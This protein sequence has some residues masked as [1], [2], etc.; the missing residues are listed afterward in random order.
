MD[1]VGQHLIDSPSNKNQE[2]HMNKQL[3]KTSARQGFTTR[4]MP[5]VLGI[6]MVLAIV[7]L[8][9]VTGFF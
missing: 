5:I 8:A 6:S 7:A 3:D 4:Y 2:K 1:A 9:A